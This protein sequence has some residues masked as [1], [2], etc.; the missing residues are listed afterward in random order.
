MSSQPE[1]ELTGQ[2][3]QGGTDTSI[4]AA[5]ERLLAMES[6]QDEP[7]QQEPGEPESGEPAE[8]SEQP[9]QPETPAPQRVKVKVQGEELELEL[10]ELA[11]G[12]MKG[13]D[14]SRKT[15]EAAE[16]RRKAEAEIARYQQEL[17]PRVAQL[18]ASLSLLHKELIGGQ[19][20]LEQLIRT[21]PAEYLAR[22][23][24]LDQKAAL[25]QQALQQRQALDYQ[26]QAEAEKAR[27]ARVAEEG[28]RLQ[29]KLPTWRDAS[30]A[31]AEQREIA[32]VLVRDYGYDPSEVAEVL[33]HRAVL[34][35]RDAMLYRKQ[36]QTK[37]QQKATPPPAVKPG[38]P[39]PGPS[40]SD[41]EKALQREL[42][43]TGNPE[44]AA[45][46]MLLRSKKK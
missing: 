25:F 36:I 20:E 38:T 32:E 4:E 41:R 44:I 30:K 27:Q 9:E 1:R 19:Q 12:Y 29:E 7:E 11:A 33:D 17:A 42:K 10:E 8:P 24:Q 26:Q 37:A 40:V 35:A 3:D 39:N 5:A 21:N 28:K 6:E 45:E 22:K 23:H 43:R 14:Y 46:L 34:L 2:D 16:L 13:A 18:D 15:A 31:Q